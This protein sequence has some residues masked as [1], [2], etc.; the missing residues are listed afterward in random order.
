METKLNDTQFQMSKGKVFGLAKN[1]E[2]KVI[3]LLADYRVSAKEFN[4]F[5]EANR[6]IGQKPWELILN[7]IYVIEQIAKKNENEKKVNENA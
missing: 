6:Y 4:N 7:S 1:K 3:I 5:E 2:G